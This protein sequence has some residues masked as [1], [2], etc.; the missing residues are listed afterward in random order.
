MTDIGFAFEPTSVEDFTASKI[1]PDCST[2]STILSDFDGAPLFNGQE[3]YIAVIAYDVYLN[4]Q[5]TGVEIVTAVPVDNLNGEVIPP[6]RITSIEVSDTPN[7]EG[8][9]IDITWTVSDSDDFGYYTVWVADRPL[10]SV[11]SLWEQYGTNPDICGC[12]VIDVQWFDEET[13]PTTLAANNGL[14]YSSDA[15]GETINISGLIRANTELYVAVS[16]HNDDGD[17]YLTGLL[18][19]SVTPINNLQDIIAPERVEILT[20]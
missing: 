3:Y 6:D 12:V 20:L 15:A 19:P 9:S 8:T 7:D 2:N 4:S 5:R 11:A 14:Y 10:D 17:A 13:K 18:S 16:V 1:I